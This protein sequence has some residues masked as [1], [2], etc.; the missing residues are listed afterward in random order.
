MRAL[1][2]RHAA[3]QGCA[4]RIVESTAEAFEMTAAFD[5]AFSINV[6]EHVDDVEQ[7]IQRIA[8]SLVPGGTYR[9]TC[10]NYLFPYEPH[11][12]IPTLFSK[13]LTERVMHA[14]IYGRRHIGDPAGLWKS[15]NWINVVA[16]RR[17]A[18]R[19]PAATMSFDTELL[20]TT[21]ERTATDAQFAARRSPLMRSVMLGLVR[22]RLHRLSAMAPAAIQPIIDCRVVRR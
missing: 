13:R 19:L 14:K 5:Y 16:L 7:S 15:L 20:V 9:F 11:F 4:P 1:I 6:M 22:L 8:A 17:I 18:R 3:S 10:A 2:V 12:N 21:P